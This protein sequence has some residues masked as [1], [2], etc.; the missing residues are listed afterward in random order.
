[1]KENNT[2]KNQA[3]ETEQKTQREES[4]EESKMFPAKYVEKLRREC[5]RYRTALKDMQQTYEDFPPER[6][7]ESKKLKEAFAKRE[8]EEGK[9]KLELKAEKIDGLIESIA[10]SSFAIAPKQVA[11][12]LR[13]GID[14]DEE[15]RVFVADR[16]GL[17]VE[18]FV[19]EFLRNN[20]HL[21]RSKSKRRGANT[22]SSAVNMFSI[23]QVSKMTAEQYKRN[24]DR[25][26]KS[27]SQNI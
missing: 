3:E 18:E 22:N 16:D 13:G 19:E 12:L 8:K 11:A 27:L 20:L 25:I 6:I 9:K 1:M 5:S 24:R 7:E 17:S 4:M 21:V 15:G 23:E 10:E 14:I 26:L 2:T